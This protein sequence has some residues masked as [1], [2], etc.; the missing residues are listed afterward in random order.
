ME[1]GKLTPCLILE[2]S[3]IVVIDVTCRDNNL[4]FSQMDTQMINI[5][6]L[7]NILLNLNAK[8]HC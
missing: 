4:L 6:T 5:T 1:S 3:G 7:G 2:Y 8:I